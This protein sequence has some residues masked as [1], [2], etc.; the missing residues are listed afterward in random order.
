MEVKGKVYLIDFG[1]ALV[2]DMNKSQEIYLK[3]KKILENCFKI[4]CEKYSKL[5]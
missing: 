1:S 2:Y 4:Y 3:N 5:G